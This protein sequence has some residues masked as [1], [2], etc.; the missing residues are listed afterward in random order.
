MQV[1]AKKIVEENFMKKMMSLMAGLLA[2]VALAM[3]PSCQNAATI[4]GVSADGKGGNGGGTGGG[5]GGGEIS[6]LYRLADGY[7]DLSQ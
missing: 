5:S 7:V 6:G 2:F 3:L 1:L 4:G